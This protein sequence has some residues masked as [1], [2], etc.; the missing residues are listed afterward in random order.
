M[1]DRMRGSF[2]HL[3]FARRWRLTDSTLLNLGQC[4]AIIECMQNMPIDPKLQAQLRQV[5]F[6]RGAQATT[7]IEGNTLS[8]EELQ[9]LLDGKELPK[10][11]E[12]QAQ[13]VKNALEAMQY[14]WS[15]VIQE[16]SDDR[17]TTPGRLR[18]D[19]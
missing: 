17:V 2:P 13:E 9:E 7:A 8:D 12:Y 18:H 4:V 6:S 14:V 10:S 3:E 15:K 16:N 5:A 1:V 19:G 11:R